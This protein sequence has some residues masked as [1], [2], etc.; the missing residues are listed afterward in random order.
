MGR[1]VVAPDDSVLISSRYSG[2]R[3]GLAGTQPVVRFGS[4]AYAS[5]VPSGLTAGRRPVVMTAGVPPPAG[6]ASILLEQPLLTA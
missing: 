6:T 5:L 4:C 1:L 3:F 2:T